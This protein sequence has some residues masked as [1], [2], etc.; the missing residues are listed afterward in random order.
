MSA[1]KKM[2]LKIFFS[3]VLLLIFF[4]CDKKS[5]KPA[6]NYNEITLIKLSNV[7]GK[8]GNYRNIKITKDSIKLEQGVVAK[9]I[10]KTWNSSISPEIWKQLSSTIDIKTLDKVKSSESKQAKNGI[11]ETFQIKTT[12]KSHVFVNSY[13]DTIHYKQFRKFKSQLEKILPK[14]YK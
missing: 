4:S 10:H 14:E 11:D 9:N 8:L 5:E 12:K 2:G 1:I 3:T 13:N 6:T 7:G